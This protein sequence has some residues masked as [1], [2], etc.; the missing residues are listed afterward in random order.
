MNTEFNWWLL[1]VG[2]VIGG[3]TVWLVLA[4]TRRDEA[5]VTELERESEARWIGE[6]MRNAG[7]T[8]DDADALDVLR[9]HEAYL[10]APPPDDIDEGLEREPA[11]PALPGWRS[12]TAHREDTVG[13]G[14]RASADG[15]GPMA[16]RIGPAEPVEGRSQDR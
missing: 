6:A 12:A 7:R 5:D 13:A 14:G 16:H 3:G 8:I 11:E 9:L 1:I 15:R 4:I 10:S 2:L